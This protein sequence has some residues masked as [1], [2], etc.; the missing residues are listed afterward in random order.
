MATVSSSTLSGDS[1]WEEGPMPDK[2]L[3]PEMNTALH[4]SACG[5]SFL[6]RMLCSCSGRE[7]SEE[8]GRERRE[9]QREAEWR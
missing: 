8:V 4:Q 2:L 6:P 1:P 9:A 5:N 3:S 7:V